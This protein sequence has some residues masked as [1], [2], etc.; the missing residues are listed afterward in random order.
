M[1]EG[2][3]KGDV[4]MQ[5]RTGI[6]PDETAGEL[7][8]RLAELAALMLPKAI[9]LVAQPGYPRIAQDQSRA[10]YAHKLTK[11]ERLIPWDKPARVLHNLIR[12]LSP[13]PAAYSLLRGQRLEILGT[14][15]AEDRNANPGELTIEGRDLFCGTG[16]GSL[17][18]LRV[19]PEGGRVMSGSDLVNGHRIR[20][21]EKLASPAATEH[22]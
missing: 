6:G 20:S 11:P 2:I 15:L 5:E 12:A 7:E 4:V 22:E 9:A 8:A 16:H 3:D 10:S 1:N 19:K 18:L 13:A 21:G 17:R 14:G